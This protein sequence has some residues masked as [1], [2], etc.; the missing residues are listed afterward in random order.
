MFLSGGGWVGC[1][2]WDKTANSR[3]VAFIYKYSFITAVCLCAHSREK[4][5][6]RTFWRCVGWQQDLTPYWG[7]RRRLG[8]VLGTRWGAAVLH[9]LE[10][11]PERVE[12]FRAGSR[13]E[14]GVLK[15]LATA[16]SMGGEKKKLAR[17]N[18]FVWTKN[19][20]GPWFASKWSKRCL[21][22]GPCCF[23]ASLTNYLISLLWMNPLHIHIYTQKN[24]LKEER[25]TTRTVV[26]SA[27][28]DPVQ[29]VDSLTRIYPECD[30]KATEHV[31]WRSF[32][33]WMKPAKHCI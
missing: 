21:L 8:R 4:S 3:V 1:L 5:E 28:R 16:T 11:L 12:M 14:K 6:A 15:G 33:T 7:A 31:G 10:M 23:L 13:M 25:R 20:C 19:V 9:S 26:E 22:H 2:G 30:F 32:V 17:T 24:E 27:L 18:K 29:R